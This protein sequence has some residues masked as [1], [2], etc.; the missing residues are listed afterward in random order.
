MLLCIFDIVQC[1]E[2]VIFTG[3]RAIEESILLF[4]FS[5]NSVNIVLIFFP[6]RFEEERFISLGKTMVGLHIQTED[7]VYHIIK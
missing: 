5:N 2:L 1:H 4:S 3:Y 6:S 7:D